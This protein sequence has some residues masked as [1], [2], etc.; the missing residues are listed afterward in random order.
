MITRKRP[1]ESEFGAPSKVVPTDDLNA[2]PNAVRLAQ[3][4]Y[5]DIIRD[6]STPSNPSPGEVSRRVSPLP[7]PERR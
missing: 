6:R 1:D 5:S 2:P 7:V 3:Q 4:R